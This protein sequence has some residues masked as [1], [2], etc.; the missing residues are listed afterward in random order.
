MFFTRKQIGSII[1]VTHILMPLGLIMGSL[2]WH[3]STLITYSLYSVM[4]FLMLILFYRA[5]Y[6]EF[7]I[8]GL[9]YSYLV[10]MAITVVFQ[11]HRGVFK[12][13]IS[14]NEMLACFVMGVISILLL[15]TCIKAFLAMRKPKES[16]SLAFP[17]RGEDYLITDGGN[18]KMSS[19]MNYHYK[20]SVHGKRSTNNSMRYAVDITQLNTRGKT[21]R[22]LL[23]QNNEDY[24]I[25]GKVVYAPISG[26]I[27]QL[28]DGIED[29]LPFP[30]TLDYSVGNHVVIQH[31][32][33][34]IVIGHFQKNSLKVTLGQ[35]VQVGDELALV[36]N[37]GLTPRPHIHM[38]VSKCED[39]DFWAAEGVS[40]L[41]RNQV[42]YKNRIFEGEKI[43]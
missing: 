30:G 25:Y 37:S 12:A 31:E 26:K 35:E 23:T 18:G 29:N 43:Q 10:L 15:V 14:K 20:A 36:G 17:L 13:S 5:G 9:R 11:I 4:T 34:Y 40:I 41:F 42:P 19:L 8:Y 32:E 1:L 28:E 22:N 27:V 39:G 24:V 33:Y 38:Q 2:L 16:L 6:W 7:T 3:G 21:V